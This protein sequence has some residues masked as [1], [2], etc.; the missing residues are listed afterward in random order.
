MTIDWTPLQALL[1]IFLT[2]LAIQ[3]LLAVLALW[4]LS[5]PHRRVS[6]GNKAVWVVV[7]LLFQMLGPLAYFLI[8]REDD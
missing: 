1:P 3:V 2:L 6:G 5:R 4:D 7:I 8:G